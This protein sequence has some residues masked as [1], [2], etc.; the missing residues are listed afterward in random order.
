MNLLCVLLGASGD[1]VFV[2]MY[3]GHNEDFAGSDLSQLDT[4]VFDQAAVRYKRT[5][6]FLLAEPVKFVRKGRCRL[7][8]V[9]ATSAHLILAYNT[10]YQTLFNCLRNYSQVNRWERYEIEGSKRC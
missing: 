6:L 3:P 7:L 8:L 1:H 5:C 9:N 4:W 10:H 2:Q